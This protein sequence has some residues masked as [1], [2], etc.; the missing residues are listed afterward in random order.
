MYVGHRLASSENLSTHLDRVCHK[1]LPVGPLDSTRVPLQ[2]PN[3]YARRIIRISAC[4]GRDPNLAHELLLR[5]S[6]S[7]PD[8]R[9]RFGGMVPAG[10]PLQPVSPCIRLVGCK[11]GSQQKFEVGVTWF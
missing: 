10:E 5:S 4:G 6:S 11:M 7:L 8:F 1:G 2:L 3:S 9:A